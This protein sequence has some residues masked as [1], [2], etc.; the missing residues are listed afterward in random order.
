MSAK[1]DLIDAC[2]KQ[3]MAIGESKVNETMLDEIITSFGPSAFK[4][5][6]QL[7]AFSDEEEVERL[8]NS[9]VNAKMGVKIDK[10]AVEWLKEKF[11]GQNRR[12]RVNVYYLLKNK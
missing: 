7:V 8:M 5:D 12:M 11:A 10:P 3:L 9:A 2:K 6:A 4:P 1:A